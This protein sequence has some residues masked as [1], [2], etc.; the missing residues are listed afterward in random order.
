MRTLVS[1]SLIAVLAAGLFGVTTMFAQPGP[2]NGR[3][4]ADP[5]ANVNAS[6]NRMMSFDANQDGQLTKEEITDSRLISLFDRA[7][8]NADG[9]LTKEE[10]TAEFTKEAASLA[11][12]GRGFP[13][14]GPEGPGGPGGPGAGGPGGPPIGQ[15][16]PDFVQ[17]ELKLTNAQKRRLEALQKTVDARL[18][19]ILTDEQKQQLAEMTNR[20]PGGPGRPGPGGPPPNGQRRPGGNRQRGPGGPPGNDRPGPPPQ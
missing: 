10:L 17:D 14:G 16:M 1:R 2:P 20:G 6:V 15:V 8:A 12:G 13:G 7:D 19:E 9:K 5:S 4:G 11:Q 18:A 3:G